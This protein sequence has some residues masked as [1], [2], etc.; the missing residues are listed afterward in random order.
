MT[1]Q[2]L[3]NR[4]DE[5]ERANDLAGI[6]RLLAAHPE[7]VAS[8][9]CAS[10]M[11]HWA[12]QE[13]K[14]AL[15]ALLVKHGV[16]INSPY[17]P[18]APD[19]PIASAAMGNHTDTVRWLVEHGSDLN[20]GQP[21]DDR[22]FCYP[23]ALAV[24]QGNL[25]LVKLLVERGAYLNV[26]DRRAMTP[27]SWAIAFRRDEIEA[28][29]RSRGAKQWQELPPPPPIEPSKAVLDEVKSVWGKVEEAGWLPVPADPPDVT[30]R[31]SRE[32]GD[33]ACVFT[34]GLAYHQMSVPPGDEKYRFAELVVYLWGW[35]ADPAAWLTPDYVWPIRWMQRLA[36]YV[37]ESG[38]WLGGKTAM[39][40]NGE[41]PA[42]FAPGTELSCWLLL[43]DKDPLE[44]V[45]FAVDKSVV[46]YTMIP[47][48]TVERDYAKRHG[49]DALLQRFIDQD[50][51]VLNRVLPRRPSVV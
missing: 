19:R 24:Q 5:L 12:A 28:Y 8:P 9:E 23:L 18:Q 44:R 29:L 21:S 32:G 16:D 4:Y 10:M 45:D 6:A 51:E 47:L 49:I 17:R 11:I 33:P 20:W 36:R 14:T 31:L 7:M 30:I 27:L 41:P 26:L 42:S 2:E 46:F 15:V 43:A 35:P 37:V 25:E 38:S 39:I 48:Y 34:Q 40:S 22:V 3:R 1:L 50:G 13:G